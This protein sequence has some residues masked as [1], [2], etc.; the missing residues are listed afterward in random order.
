M[1]EG[2]DPALQEDWDALQSDSEVPQVLPGVSEACSPQLVHPC[3]PLWTIP[4]SHLKDHSWP[5]LDST[6]MEEGL[7]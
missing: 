1:G 5:L 2:F 4:W 3:S 7:V 6:V